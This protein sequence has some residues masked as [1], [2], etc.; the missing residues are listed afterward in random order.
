MAKL[1]PPS[2]DEFEVDGERVFIPGGANIGWASNGIHRNKAVLE[3]MRIYLGQRGWLEA[4]DGERLEKMRRV[5]D[6]NFGYGK[7]YCLGRL[8]ALSELHKMIFEVSR[9]TEDGV[10]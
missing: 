8:I 1:C 7:Y 10:V 2:G 3:R 5:V 6:L 4:G 9:E